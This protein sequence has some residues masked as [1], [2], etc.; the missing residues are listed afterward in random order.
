MITTII[1]LKIIIMLKT[2]IIPSIEKI[3]LVMEI[4]ITIIRSII[5]IIVVRTR[6][7]KTTIMR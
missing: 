7:I 3:M 5:M 1:I 2:A 6:A 4:T